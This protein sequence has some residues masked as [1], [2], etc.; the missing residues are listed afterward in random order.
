MLLSEPIDLQ[1]RV[2]MTSSDVLVEFRAGLMRVESKTL[3]A[4][5]RKGL[6]RFSQVTFGPARCSGPVCQA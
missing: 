1:L 2:P 6:V 4:D 5:Q 3:K